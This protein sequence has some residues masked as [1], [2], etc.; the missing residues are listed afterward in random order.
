MIVRYRSS[1]QNDVRLMPCNVVSDSRRI[2][3]I[4]LP[5]RRRKQVGF[6][7]K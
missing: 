7:L 6:E 2:R 3:N 5:V 1:M 4:K